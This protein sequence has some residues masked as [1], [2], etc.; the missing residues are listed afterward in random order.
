[1]IDCCLAGCFV[2]AMVAFG[3]GMALPSPAKAST[4]PTNPTDLTGVTVNGSFID[5]CGF[6]SPVFSNDEF[7]GCT[8]GFGSAGG[9]YSGGDFGGGDGGGG[10]S[11]PSNPS[12]EQQCT[13]LKQK[14][15]EGCGIHNYPASPGLP[16][17]ANSGFYGNGCGASIWSTG[18]AYDYLKVR[19]LLT[20]S[21]DLNR[22]IKGHSGIDFTGACNAHD[23]CYTSSS[24]KSTCDDRLLTALNKVCGNSSEP[25]LCNEFADTYHD[26]V[27][28]LGSDAYKEDQKDLKCSQW[29]NKMK[30]NG[31]N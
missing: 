25:D 4:D 1:L 3:S 22:P 16:S 2:L 26:A 8:G 18:L 23:G 30:N 17:S 20:F 24:A 31:C 28:K 27:D 15:P 29:G 6:G 12:H 19:H 21:G 13:A 14:R 9:G 10:G 5:N 11:G 7:V